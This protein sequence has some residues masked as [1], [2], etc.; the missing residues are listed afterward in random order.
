MEDIINSRKYKASTLMDDF[1]KTCNTINH[2]FR[3]AFLSPITITLGD[4]F[5][6][7]V[8]SLKEGIDII[9]NF[10]EKIIF[11]RK[12]FKL[13]FVL[14]YGDIETQINPDKAYEMLGAGLTE[15]RNML[16]VEKHK[17]K[18]FIIDVDNSKLSLQ[19]NLAFFLFQSIV[20]KWKYKDYS[21][22]S[23]FLKYKDYKKVAKVIKKDVSSVWRREKG[24]K[25]NE[26]T[27]AKEL[28][29]SLS[30]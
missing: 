9:I 21:T 19:L 28:L 7:I 22:I 6:S 14:H 24:L 20:D 27:S 5:Q 26:Y 30:D 10:E 16:E 11:T 23:A 4:E 13:R 12:Y 17:D 1:K 3:G 8:S 15:A 18:R 25:I 29:H 2:D